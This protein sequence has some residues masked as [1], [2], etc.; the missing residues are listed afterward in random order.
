MSQVSLQQP[1][2]ALIEP[3]SPAAHPWWISAAVM[4]AAFMVV[5]DS[6]V[7]NVA[8]PHIA[9]N[10]SASIDESTWT[11]TSYLV[12]NAIVLPMTGW[13]SSMVGRKN[14]LLCCLLVFILASAACGTATTLSF[15]IVARVIQ[16]LGGGAMQPIAQAVL[17]ESFPPAR[18]GVA[19]AIYGLGV[20][21]APIVGPTLG[22]W[23]TDTYSWR[24]V[25]YINMPVGMLSLLL[26][27]VFIHDPAY[28]RQGRAQR[29]DYIG[30]V[31]MAVG[32]GCLHVMLDKG[33][34]EDW[35][36]SSLI[37]A[38]LVLS[39]VGLVAFVF[40]ELYVKDPIVNL[41]IFLNRNF[42]VGTLLM[43]IVGGVMYGATAILPLFLQTLLGYPAY[44]SG[45]A[46]SPRGFGSFMAMFMASRLIGRIDSRWM[47]LIG[48]AALGYSTYT[49]GNFNLDIAPI[50]IIW[51]NIINGFAT[52][53]IFVPM[54]TIAMG[55]LR[56]EEIGNATSLYN[57]LRNIGAGI[58]I[59]MMTTFLARGAQ[60]HQAAMVSHMTVY[61]PAYQQQLQTI[62]SALT[63][64]SG[65]YAAG[66]QA[67]S[68]MGAQL[69]R[70]ATLWSYVDNFRAMAF[71]SLACILGIFF[72]RSSRANKNSSRHAAALD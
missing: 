27:Q 56:N 11:L 68:V 38:L 70:Q 48:F 71:I 57:L 20:I 66:L 35:L 64:I 13:L 34:Q 32:L 46:V 24:W 52:G 23:I 9:G 42:A 50:N 62:H 49:M 40:W 44:Q 53:L 16:G 33:Q 36:A 37:R 17:L 19:M 12:A 39:S 47:L 28:I 25:F 51:P 2:G 3:K 5:L 26:V 7:V 22:G 15:L 10:L 6:T 31:L 41:R 67:Q 54:T 61:D 55:T 18:R 29:I 8:L 59:A 4:S 60:T 69:L 14:L 21:F 43:T 58:G 30:F 45:L 65:S 63:P 1:I 72:L